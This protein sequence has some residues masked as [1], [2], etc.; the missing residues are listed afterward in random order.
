M[1]Y[2]NINGDHLALTGTTWTPLCSIWKL[3][4]QHFSTTWINWRKLGDNF[5]TTVGPLWDHR[6]TTVGPQWH[7]NETPFWD[8]FEITLLLDHC[9]TTLRKLWNS[10]EK[11]DTS[12]WHLWHRFDKTLIQLWHNFKTVSGLL[13]ENLETTLRPNSDYLVTIGGSYLCPAYGYFSFFATWSQR[14]VRKRDSPKSATTARPWEP[15]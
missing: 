15:N 1:P 4:G 2:G 6:G 11:I 12:L 14:F 5:G 9:E 10:F 8:I 3:R 13:L 7:I